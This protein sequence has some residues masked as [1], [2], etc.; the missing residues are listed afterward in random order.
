M[1]NFIKKLD[2]QRQNVNI[3]YL[4]NK[5]RLNRIN[6]YFLNKKYDGVDKL[7]IFQLLN[8]LYGIG[9]KRFVYFFSSFLGYSF[10]YSLILINI[11]KIYYLQQQIRVLLLNYELMKRVSRN[12]KI[13]QYIG[14]YQGVRF[15]LNLPIRGQRTKTNAGTLKQKRQNYSIVNVKKKKS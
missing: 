7:K 11:E 15:K 14:L 8:D 4:V 1:I 3:L 6:F 12:L 5:E 13:K 10:L 9:L 2:L